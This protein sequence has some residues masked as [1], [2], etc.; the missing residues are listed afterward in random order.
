MR[1]LGEITVVE[2]DRVVFEQ[3]VIALK[4]WCDENSYFGRI[5]DYML[6]QAMEY[7]LYGEPPEKGDFLEALI[8][9]RAFSEVVP[10]ADDNNM[11]ALK[12][13][14]ILL[15]NIFPS[16]S[17][18]SPERMSSWIGHEG[19]R[20]VIPEYLSIYAPKRERVSG[21]KD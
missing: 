20:G 14:H 21:Q 13:W 15:Y 1:E 18:R 4:Y 7:I 17:W 9:D 10:L 6:S 16:Q 8:E 19:T 5:P 12:T 11:R 3:A 2:R